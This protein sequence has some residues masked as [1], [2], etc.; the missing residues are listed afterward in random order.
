M[1]NRRIL[2]AALG[3]A[4]AVGLLAGCASQPS[5][6][7]T[8]EAPAADD[9]TFVWEVDDAYTGPD[10]EF[11]SQVERPAAI[12]DGEVTVGFLQISGAQQ[13]LK[14]M[15]EAAKAE[16]EALGGTLIVK[17]AGLDVQKQ[18]SQIDE[19]IAQKVDVIIGYPVV[20]AALTPGVQAA[21]AAGIPFVALMTPPDVTQ[22]ALEGVV[23]NVNQAI[24]YAVWSSMNHLAEEHPGASFAV[25]GFAAPVDTLTYISE[26]QIY[27]GEELGLQ[28][29]GRVD[30]QS[31]APA[32]YTTAAT[33][34]LSK[35]PEVEIVV[36]YND[37]SSL[38][39]QAAAASTGKTGIIFANPNS[40]QSIAEDGLRE[41]RLDVVFRTAWERI[42]TVAA[43]VAMTVA[44]D[45]E[46]EFP[47]TINVPGI[48]VTQE[49]AGE[50]PW[51]G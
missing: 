1:R 24:D 10:K 51:I 13:V 38:A 23:T 41:E 30:A 22:P 5:T 48:L 34:L 14:A 29:L 3:F 50:V 8:A 18:Q 27:W 11:F 33:A 20:G 35:Y 46:V 21:T 17:D 42:G 15:E 6:T 49:T 2:S 36:A 16:V 45:P 43:D 19:L 47:Q 7:D 4:T 26:R 37:Q 40:G 9:T 12:T 39:A 25:M 28:Y 32:G 31:D 44:A